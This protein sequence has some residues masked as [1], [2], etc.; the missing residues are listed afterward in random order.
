M[1]QFGSNFTMIMYMFMSTVY[2]GNDGDR[3]VACALTAD[4]LLCNLQQQPNP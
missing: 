2:L 1:T 3:S 4:D